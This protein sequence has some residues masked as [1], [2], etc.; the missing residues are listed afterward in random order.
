MVRLDDL[1]LATGC[2]LRLCLALEPQLKRA[3][4]KLY[5]SGESNLADLLE[6]QDEHDITVKEAP[7]DDEVT[8]LAASAADASDAPIV[9][10]VNM[11]IYQGIKAKASDIHIEPFEKRVVVRYR[12]DGNMAEAMTPP[13]KLQNAITSRLKIMASLDIAEKRRPQDGKFQVK[14]E[15]R[16]IDFRVSASSRRCTARRSCCRILDST[17][18]G[19]NLD[20]LGFEPQALE[21][22]K[23][24]ID[25]PYGMI[26]VTGPTGSGKT[27]TLYSAVKE[28][29]TPGDELRHGRGPGRVPARGRQPGPGEREARPHVR[30]RAA[31]DPA[32]GPRHRDG[33]RDPRHRDDRDRGQGGPHR[34]PRALDAPHQRRREHRH[35]HGAT[36]ASTRSWCRPPRCS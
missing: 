32:P 12:V 33:R 13:K 21:D 16:Q 25:A 4:D 36:W 6:E 26:L 28:M 22:F 29:L 1:R 3:T 9:K 5:H 30:R 31:L 18:L 17:N 19:R 11:I 20:T 14:V 7:K 2:E 10:L 35:A 34:P 27:T 8:D 15:G 23:N 24:A